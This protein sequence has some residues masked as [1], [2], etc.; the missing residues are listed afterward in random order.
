MRGFAF[1]A[2]A[3]MVMDFTHVTKRASKSSRTN[4]GPSR[5]M[6]AGVAAELFIPALW[7]L[8]AKEIE[9]F[10]QNKLHNLNHNHVRQAQIFR[11][12]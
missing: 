1:A 5:C 9:F 10:S 12:N 3:Q 11:E 4:R 2:T 7:K 8:S 6:S